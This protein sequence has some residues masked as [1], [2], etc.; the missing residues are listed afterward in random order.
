M[1]LARQSMESINRGWEGEFFNVVS[2]G[3]KWE[4]FSF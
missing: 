3:Q 4:M 1:F 2:L